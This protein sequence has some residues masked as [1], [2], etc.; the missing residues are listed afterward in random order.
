MSDV[1]PAEVVACPLI[2]SS[3]VDAGFEAA[4]VDAPLDEWLFEVRD[5]G[6]I[7]CAGSHVGFEDDPS[8]PQLDVELSVVN[9]RR[10]KSTNRPARP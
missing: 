10:T 2:D 5:D 6:G 9:G 7:T 8:F 1:A 4:G 3:E